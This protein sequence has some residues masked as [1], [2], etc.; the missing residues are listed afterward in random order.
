MTTQPASEAIVDP[1]PVGVDSSQIRRL[2]SS[3]LR[4]RLRL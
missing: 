4:K 2:A 1:P 3:A